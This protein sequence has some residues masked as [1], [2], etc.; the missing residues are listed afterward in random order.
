MSRVARSVALGMSPE[1]AGTMGAMSVKT[2]LVATGTVITDA[3]DLVAE[4]N[5]ITTSAASTGVQLP[6]WPIGSTV[7]VKN[8]S[9]QTLNI[10]PHSAAGNIFTASTGAGAGTAVT[11]VD[12]KKGRLHRL[13]ATDWDYTLEN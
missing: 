3:L 13:T 5:L 2:G 9:G 10:F 7:Y 12:A 8:A 6:D 1:L 4:F 11:I